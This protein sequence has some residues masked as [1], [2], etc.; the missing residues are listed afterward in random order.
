LQTAG[1]DFSASE[2]NNN[3]LNLVS[4]VTTTTTTT[5]KSHNSQPNFFFILADDLGYNSV[6]YEAH[7][8]TSVAPYLTS[9]A[10]GVYLDQIEFLNLLMC[11]VVT[12]LM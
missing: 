1:K 11:F 3:K 5:T 7:D 9:L 6:G 8:L 10:K 12:Y 4:V 2:N